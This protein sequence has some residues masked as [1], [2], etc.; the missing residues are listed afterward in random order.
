MVVED[1]KDQEEGQDI[2]GGEHQVEGEDE[3]EEEE[4]ELTDE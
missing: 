4:E 1:N 3:G 2:Y